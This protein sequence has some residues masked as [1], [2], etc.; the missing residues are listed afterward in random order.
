M[1]G[2][3]SGYGTGSSG[4][5]TDETGEGGEVGPNVGEED[6]GLSPE[7]AIDR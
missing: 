6:E 7:V 2:E 3:R 5:L 4:G 1:R